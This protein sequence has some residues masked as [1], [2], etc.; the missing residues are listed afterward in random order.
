MKPKFLLIALIAVVI[1][2]ISCNQPDTVK[3]EPTKESNAATMLTK[4]GTADCEKNYQFEYFDKASLLTLLQNSNVKGIKISHEL[5]TADNNGFS[6][7]VI[8]PV[9]ID[10]AISLQS[11]AIEPTKRCPTQCD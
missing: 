10:T 7:V 9:L 2:A 11:T 4:S 8:K 3:A 6:K 1:F 5:N